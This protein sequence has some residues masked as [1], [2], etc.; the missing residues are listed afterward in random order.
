MLDQP[1]PHHHLP[2]IPAVAGKH[3]DAVREFLQQKVEFARAEVAVEEGVDL[4]VVERA[5]G[6]V[7]DEAEVFGA[8]TDLREDVLRLRTASKGRE[9]WSGVRRERH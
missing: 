3:L 7:I 9:K 6:Q 2:R 5:V 4:R 8:E 1:P